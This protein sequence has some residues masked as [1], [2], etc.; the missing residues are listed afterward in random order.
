MLIFFL[1]LLVALPF[2]DQRIVAK[3]D[4]DVVLLQARQVRAN[5]KLS[6]ALEHVHLRVPKR[7][8]PIE[9]RAEA[10]RRQETGAEEAIYLL[11][12][13]AEHIERRAEERVI[14]A[15]A[16]RGFRRRSRIL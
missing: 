8:R 1:M 5:D 13:I 11:G 9:P 6:I 15:S 12:H 10:P 4:F 14:V 7:L 16:Q 3:L 2:K